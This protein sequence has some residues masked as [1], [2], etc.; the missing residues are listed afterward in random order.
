M[1]EVFRN[2]LLDI[3]HTKNADYEIISGTWDERFEKAIA[4][5]E[6]RWPSGLLR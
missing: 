4:A 5:I 6:K 2:K 3:L 1:R